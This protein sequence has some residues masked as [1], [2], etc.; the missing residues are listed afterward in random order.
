MDTIEDLVKECHVMKEDDTI[1][2][3]LRLITGKRADMVAVVDRKGKLA[4]TLIERDLL[5]V[6]VESPLAAMQPITNGHVNGT[7]LKEPVTAIMRQ[8]LC[9]RL[10]D[11]PHDILAMMASQEFKSLM[12]TDAEGRPAGCVRL[13]DI[14]RRL[15]SL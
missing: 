1:E 9:G 11:R 8:P 12:I 14:I 4:G 3:F 7:I 6:V 10:S 2:D 15:F 5:K 13:A